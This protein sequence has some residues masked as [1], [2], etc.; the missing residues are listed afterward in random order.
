MGKTGYDLPSLR[1]PPTTLPAQAWGEVA[2]SVSTAIE[3]LKTLGPKRR[4]QTFCLM[5]VNGVLCVTF[6][7]LMLLRVSPI[8]RL[9]PQSI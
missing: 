2:R 9:R 5:Y 3:N 8:P 6:V 4:W 7:P 1:A